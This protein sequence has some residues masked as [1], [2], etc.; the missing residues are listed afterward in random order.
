MVEKSLTLT[1]ARINASLFSA[2]EELIVRDSVV[3]LVAGL[4][5]S[6]SRVWFAESGRD[7]CL[8]KNFRPALGLPIFLGSR[9][10]GVRLPTQLHQMSRLRMN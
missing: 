4:W 1:S 8:L 9:W 2:I 5:A 10:R 3:D 6:R 7:F